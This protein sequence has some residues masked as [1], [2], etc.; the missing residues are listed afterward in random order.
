[1]DIRQAHMDQTQ[2][3]SNEPSPAEAQDRAKATGNAAGTAAGLSI[4]MGEVEKF[5][6]MADAWWDPKG[7]FRPLHLINPIR[8]DYIVGDAA[9]HFGRDRAEP[10]P[11][12]GLRILDVGCGGGLA[13]EPLARLGAQVTG[14]DA[15]A[16]NIPVAQIHASQSGLDIEYVNATVEELAESGRTFDI[17]LALEIIEHV[18]EPPAFIE[19]LHQV[20]APDGFMVISTFNKTA[21][22]FALGIVAAEYVL[23]WLP[24]GTHE[25]QRFVPPRQM[26]A[27]VEERAGLFMTRARGMSYNPLKDR[28]TLTKDLSVNYLATFKGQESTTR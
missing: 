13:C 3:T 18:N 8:L 23:G 2:K 22:S 25:W 21:K 26:E 9:Q 11:L 1:M 19:A 7:K 10:T 24:R 14:V 15:A 17:V 28:W 12:K 20:M 4:D 6:A 5:T 16:A 27:W